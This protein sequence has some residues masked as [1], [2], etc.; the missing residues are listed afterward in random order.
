MV[1]RART[2]CRCTA[3]PCK[4]NPSLTLLTRLLMS[5]IRAVC[6]AVAS[7]MQ[8]HGAGDLTSCADL[9]DH[10]GPSEE[11]EDW[12]GLEW[13]GG[14]DRPERSDAMLCYHFRELLHRRGQCGGLI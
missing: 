4:L 1:L 13:N 7:L 2:C 9:H 14:I 6:G 8:V 11:S 5:P 12:I 3:G 10:V